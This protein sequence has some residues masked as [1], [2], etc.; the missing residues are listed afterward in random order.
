MFEFLLA[1]LVVFALYT[2]V[3]EVRELIHTIRH[4]SKHMKKGESK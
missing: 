1:V 4:Q 2:L 3:G